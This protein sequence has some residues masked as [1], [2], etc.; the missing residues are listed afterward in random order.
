[1]AYHG[2]PLTGGKRAFAAF[3]S[4]R[5][6]AKMRVQ[7]GKAGMPHPHLQPARPAS[8]DTDHLP[9][10]HCAHRGTKWGA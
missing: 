4:R 9:G 8:V 7:R 10:G 3:Q 1:V 6:Q 5:H 2:N